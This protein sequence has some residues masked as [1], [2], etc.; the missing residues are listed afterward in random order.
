MKEKGAC[1]MPSFQFIALIWRFEE[2]SHSIKLYLYRF[3]HSGALQSKLILFKL[4]YPSTSLRSG[5]D[6]N[7]M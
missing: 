4:V 2:A 5:R 1:P 3:L 6:D 7:L